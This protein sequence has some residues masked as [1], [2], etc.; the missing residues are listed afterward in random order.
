MK[1]RLWFV[2]GCSAALFAAGPIAFAQSAAVPAA[3]GT[4]PLVRVQSR[5]LDEVY[6]APKADLRG[7]TKVMLDSAQVSFAANWRKNLNEEH[8]A[9]LEERTRPDDASRI[10]DKVRKG[11]DEAFA[12]AFK[13]AGY[14]IVAA[15]G[16][17][18]I[19]LAPRL[20]DVSINAPETITM[21]RPTNRVYAIDAGEATLD[22]EL[23]DAS[24][25]ALLGRVH[26]RRT[27]G[28]RGAFRSSFRL[29]TPASNVFD[30]GGL[31]DLWA[32]DSLKVVQ[33]AKAQAPG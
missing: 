27:A 31:F 13:R 17:G 18:V 10:A 20:T 32:Q 14:E 6:L 3:Q 22:L 11:F 8:I 7:Y 2:A 12:S 4:D 28:N 26:D 16:P 5:S 21:S 9:Q 30:F 29:T 33:Q 23:V 15:P 1:I 25:G 24:T 19:R